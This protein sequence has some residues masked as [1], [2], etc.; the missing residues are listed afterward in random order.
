MNRKV[1]WYKV[2]LVWMRAWF[3][4]ILS[5]FLILAAWFLLASPVYIW[6]PPAIRFVAGSLVVSLLISLALFIFN[7]PLVKYLMGARRIERRDGSPRLWESVHRVAPN[8][9]HVIPRIY[10]VEKQGMN[11]FAFGMGLPFLSAV[12]ATRGLVDAL[13]DNELDAV[14]AHEMAHVAN[15]DMFISMVMTFSV[16]SMA[17]T[18]WCLYKLAPASFSRSRGDDGKMALVCVIAGFAMYYFGQALGYIIQL[19]ISRQ[20]EYLADAKSASYMGNGDHLISALK[21]IVKDPHVAGKKTEAFAGFL[22]TAD[23]EPSDLFSTHPSLNKRIQA[24][25]MLE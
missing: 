13:S 17:F 24:L 15:K 23:P 19:F 25:R 11:A 1:K 22:C 21:K 14:I 12:G 10:L 3:L 7:E 18:G 8:M 6:A 5:V 20:R 4:L 9:L 2:A 16:M